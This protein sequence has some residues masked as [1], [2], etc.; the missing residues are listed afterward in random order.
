[1]R[2]HALL[3]WAMISAALNAQ[4]ILPVLYYIPPTMGCNG[5]VALSLPVYNDCIGGGGG[6]MTMWPMYCINMGGAWT[7]A[8][9]VFIPLCNDPCEFA[10][11]DDFGN[12]CMCSVGL[13]TTVASA[14][15]SSLQWSISRSDGR[16]DIHSAMHVKKALCRV[17]SATGQLLTERA[18]PPGLDWR[19]LIPGTSQ[20]LVITITSEGSL[21]VARM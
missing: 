21:F 4:D 11:M 13:P 14:I 12:A 20:L 19:V 1:M 2:I 3:S 6:A 7:N 10:I 8:D 17:F 18:L 9:T 16:L 5:V 15:P